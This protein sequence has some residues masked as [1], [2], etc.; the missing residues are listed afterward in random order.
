MKG[1]SKTT[2]RLSL[3]GALVAAMLGVWMLAAGA[4]GTK[5]TDYAQTDWYDSYPSNDTYTIDSAEK[6]AGI[7]KLVNAGSVN[8]F[9]GKILQIAA[10]ID[11][12]AHDWVP[13]GTENNPF[14]G[15]LF[16]PVGQD[17]TV[18]GMNVLG[19]VTYAGLVGNAENATIGGFSIDGASSSI[20]VTATGDAVYAGSVVGKIVG[21]GT[22][23]D[24]KSGVPI[25][26]NASGKDVYAGGIAGYAEGTVSRSVYS[27]SLEATAQDAAAGGIIGY[28]GPQGVTVL[29]VTNN[30]NVT[31]EKVGLDGDMAAGGIVGHSAGFLRMEQDE[32][33]I[34][35]TGAV[36]VR[37]G[38]WS[39][40][41]G[42]VG[43]TDGIA[44]FSLSTTNNGAVLI[45]APEAIESAAGGL[46]GAMLG[47]TGEHPVRLNF[48]NSGSVTNNGGSNVYTGGF[49]GYLNTTLVFTNDT[50]SSVA[51]VATGS[52]EVHT[53]GLVG[54]AEKQVQWT[55]G[56]RNSGT[57]NVTPKVSEGILNE[58]YTGG[59]VGFSR[60]RI[61]L[62]SVVLGVYG[63]SGAVTVEGNM[64][65]YTGGIAGNRTFAGIGGAA[66][67]VSSTGDIIVNGDSRIHTGG[68]IGTLLADAADHGMAG[69]TF[70]SDIQV[71]ATTSTENDYVAT[72]GIVGYYAK[73]EGSLAELTSLSFNGVL[74]ARGGG[75]YTYSGGIAGYAGFGLFK[76]AS[77]GKSAEEYATIVSDGKLGGVAGYLN[78]ELD[79]ANIAYLDMTLLTA[80]GIAGGV[81]AQAQGL[82]NN[83]VVG[84][85]TASIDNTVIIG[86]DA[87]AGNELAFI[88]GGVIGVNTN[89]LTITGSSAARLALLNETGRSGYTLGGIAGQLTDT[90]IA[91]TIESPVSV[92]SL[93]VAAESSHVVIG[94]AIGRSDSSSVVAETTDITV[95]ASGDDI[96]AGGVIGWNEGAQTVEST[97]IEG[98]RAT[99]TAL[100]EDIEAGGIAGRNDGTIVNTTATDGSIALEGASNRGGGIA[101]SHH[102]TLADVTSVNM[103][104]VA[105]AEGAIIG[106]ITGVSEPLDEAATDPVIENATSL[107]LEA[108]LLTANAANVRMGGIAGVANDTTITNPVTKAENSDYVTLTINAPDIYAGGIA[109]QSEGGSIEGI[110]GLDN[111]NLQQLFVTTTTNAGNALVGGVTGHGVHTAIDSIYG[112][113]VNISINGSQNKVGG[114]AGYYEGTGTAVIKDSYLETLGIRGLAAAYEAVLGGAIGVND[115][116]SIDAGADPASTPST[117]QNTRLIGNVNNASSPLIDSRGPNAVV[118]GLVGVN[119]SLVANNSVIDKSVLLA[120][121]DGSIVGGHTGVNIE[122]GTLYYTYANANLSV[123][124][125]N[126]TLGGLVGLNEGS[127]LS[128]Y[129]DIDVTSQATG[130]SSQAVAVGGLVGVNEGRIAKSYSVSNV[131]AGGDYS[132]VG[133]LVGEQLGGSIRHSYSGGRVLASKT[134]SLAG[135]F[136][137]RIVAGEIAESYSAVSVEA[138]AGAEGGGFAGRYDNTSTNLIYK[139]Y[140]LKDDAAGINK[141]LPDFA[142]G[143]IRWLNVPA[144]LSTLL[145]ETLRD[146]TAFP[147]LSGWIFAEA[148]NEETAVWRYGS[149]NARYL[150]PELIRK[151]NSGGGAT[152]GVNA[153]L[154]WYT[155][156]PDAITFE[157]RSEAE[158]AGL[159]QLVNGTVLGREREDFAGKTI[160]VVNPIHIQSEN[161]TSVGASETTPFEGTFDGGGH[162]IDGLSVEPGQDMSGLFGVIGES[163]VLDHVVLEPRTIIGNGYTGT[164]AAINHGSLS[165]IKVELTEETTLTGQSVGGLAGRN[166]GSIE[167][168]TILFRAGAIIEAVGT[169]AAGGALFG[170][171]GSDLTPSDWT[172]LVLLGT[173]RSSANGAVIGGHVGRQSAGNVAGFDIVLQNEISASGIGGIAG[174]F[175]GQY[176]DGELTDITFRLQEGSIKSIGANSVAGGIVGVS[177]DG[178]TVKRL[179]LS[180][181]E[182]AAP[183]IGNTVGAVIG[184]KEGQAAD[185]YDVESLKANGVSLTTPEGAEEGAV[186]GIFGSITNAAAFDLS[187]E[188]NL[189]ARSVQ[190]NIGG[191]TGEGQ[192]SL[193]REASVQPVFAFTASGGQSAIGGIAGEMLATDR[194]LYFDLGSKLPYYVGVYEAVVPA[195]EIKASGSGTTAEIAIGG[196]VGK[197]S[198][199]IYF[200]ET[201]ATVSVNGAKL[202]ALGGIVGI[203]NG[204]IVSTDTHGGAYANENTINYVGGAVGLAS[205]GSIHYTFVTSAQDAGI[206]VSKPVTR[207]PELPAAHVGGFVGEAS[208]TDMS[209]VSTNL[210]VGVTSANQEDS[211]QVGGFAGVL[212]YNSALPEAQLEWAYA[213]GSVTSNIKTTALAG[214]FAGSINRYDVS[215][216]YA[217]GNVSNTGFDTRTGGFAGAIERGAR[218]EKGNAVQTTLSATGVNHAT[219][220]YIGGFA[221]YND[222]ELDNVYA[223]AESI[224]LAAAGASAYRGALLGYQYRGGSI[225]ESSH[226][227]AIPAIGHNL[228]SLSGLANENKLAELRLS[229]WQLRTDTTLLMSAS[230]DPYFILNP[231]QL[232]TAV[233]LANDSTGLDFYR[234][235]NRAA[236]E[237]PDSDI[238][239]GADIDLTGMIWTPFEDFRETFDGAGHTITGVSLAGQSGPQGFA[240]V[241]YGRIANLQFVNAEFSSG[242]ANTDAVGIVAGVNELDGEIE[243]INVS[244]TVNG[245]VVGGIAG[246]NKGSIAVASSTGTVS[247]VTAGGI[248]GDHAASGQ[249]EN[250]FSYAKVTAVDAGEAAAGG[251]AGISGGSISNAF[252]SGNVA[253]SGSALTRAGGIVGHAVGGSISDVVNAAEAVA[254]TNGKIARNQTFFGGIAGQKEDAATIQDGFYNRQMLK[255]DTAFY[256]GTGKRVAGG[257]TVGALGVNGAAL[258]TNALPNGLASA[259]W[260]AAAGYY[261]QL[262]AFAD[263]TRSRV[264]A[265]AIALPDGMTIYGAIGQFSLTRI[266][267]IPWS[268]TGASLTASG[269]TMAGR[270]TAPSGDVVLSVAAVG[271][272]KRE[273]LIRRTALL[274][275][276]TAAAPAFNQPDGQFEG[277]LVVGLTTTE[278]DGI[279]YYTV[280]GTEPVPGKEGTKVYEVPLELKATT[281]VRAI[282]FADDKELSATSTGKWTLKAV[283]GGGG[284]PMLPPAPVEPKMTIGDR[285]I[286]LDGKEAVQ[287][288]VNSIVKLSVPDDAIVYYTTDGTEPTKN[289]SVYTGEIWV[290][291]DMTIKFMTSKDDTVYSVRYTTKPADYEVKKN[292][293]EIRYMA[294][295]GTSFRPNEAITRQEL[296]TALALL[297]DF[298]A[299]PI[300]STFGDVTRKNASAVAKFASAGIVQGYPDGTFQGEKGLTR[301]EFVVMLSR[302]LGLDIGKGGK[303]P[304]SDTEK[305]WSGDYVRV[306]VEAG[307]VNGYPDGTFR[308]D[309]LLSRAEAI[310]LLNN[311]LHTATK[312]NA[313]IR[314]HDV[315]EDHWAYDEIMGAAKR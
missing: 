231:Y 54:H 236:T 312:A 234:L 223:H 280:N 173:V 135:G 214:G 77:A 1:K 90:A 264:S 295:K 120:R 207:L 188:G 146:R 159:A 26:V 201:D 277:T 197:S 220:A 240:T 272:P 310:V 114:I 279:I 75:A 176:V 189:T 161:W 104:L 92:E 87:V 299:T 111:L 106:G 151:A 152:P 216:A 34:L 156:N 43:K 134:G 274:F 115:T 105:N 260:K 33:P 47:E 155:R 259:D 20:D 181:D 125:Q 44:T 169:E 93:T 229:D 306:F 282:T 286:P 185:H 244:G 255:T 247:G 227:A 230:E 69:L 178:N 296:I 199:S 27:G 39:Y 56:A 3:V 8:G 248:A 19:D 200:S 71:T 59:L 85:G 166:T 215:Q 271:Q 183:V 177:D 202:A 224:S 23:Y 98:L 158:L 4:S 66:G 284:V 262:Q 190:A 192:D 290:T 149:V 55:T 311:I 298:E 24:I 314:F 154:N 233:L 293:S 107:S 127:I 21:L 204:I 252:F 82:V 225:E 261:P 182:N 124:G 150:Y 91:G 62:E 228:G 122:A 100:G 136:A 184:K 292:A 160:R 309:R 68:Y 218:V 57:I 76:N 253:A 303:S 41:G 267:D 15:T 313:S 198:A 18:S 61:L 246:I 235:Y 222:G 210:A 238:L 133:G 84:D 301:A 126:I 45:D 36:T 112:S 276:E 137:G 254:G 31:V 11:L 315:P 193:L 123:Q 2:I 167:D 219:R 103:A 157:I 281:T 168:I 6:L 109:G 139:T 170:D 96:V 67:N 191:I 7:A 288:A 287:A 153:S 49:A 221:G 232:F 95:D 46:V 130:T 88:A 162:L 239:L 13:I 308:P 86:A 97:G 249:L 302:I 164:V 145:E 270:V 251:I 163:G 245:G 269:A 211:V 14:R 72:G 297:I 294:G 289:S 64:G 99:I 48:A 52:E 53:G 147:A 108:P 148:G 83:A 304:F 194:D 37:N 25:T 10:N 78:G 187:F 79:G 265:V 60:D 142:E 128:S 266:S 174:G 119:G 186:G 89:S 40:A 165:N 131:T 74:D 35:N 305:H 116:R 29:R 180:A 195:I 129:I 102:G 94:G 110:G 140:Y 171:N 22:V 208:G 268:A 113:V 196:I 179:A 32:T 172:E 273:V 275:E 50:S 117:I 38:H 12:S 307:Y 121:G 242:S 263:S 209:H 258:S 143:N 70:G 28:G 141:D 81:A 63:N 278:P 132:L 138:T 5:W 9:E 217:S 175:I 42:I 226:A 51:I 256:D 257:S 118:G 144:R 16:T 213:T 101:A 206:E 17:F 65:L 80:S 300:A 30:S 237:T 203:S 241:N 58:V 250:V 291:G 285:D 283:F 212:G 73:P 205:G 243:N